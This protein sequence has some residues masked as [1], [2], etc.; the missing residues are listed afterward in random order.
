LINPAYCACSPKPRRATCQPIIATAGARCPG[1]GF[2]LPKPDTLRWKYGKRWMK[3]LF[4][5]RISS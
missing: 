5:K 2:R 1:I 3:T 4:R